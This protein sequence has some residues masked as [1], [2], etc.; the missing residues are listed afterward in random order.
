MASLVAR[1]NVFEEQGKETGQ[2]SCH[3][4]IYTKDRWNQWH[5]GENETG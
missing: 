2:N 3:R 1:L 4:N 5:A